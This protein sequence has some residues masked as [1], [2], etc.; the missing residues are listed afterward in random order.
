MS[1]KYLEK[2]AELEKVSLRRI[3]SEFAKGKISTP[4]SELVSKGAIKSEGVYARGMRKGNSVLAKQTNSFVQRPHSALDKALADGG[5]GYFTIPLHK[6]HNK[7]VANK[8]GFM[9]GTEVSHQASVRHE[10]FEA[11]EANHQR[12]SGIVKSI[13][14]PKILHNKEAYPVPPKLRQEVD[15]LNSNVM[16]GEMSQIT[17]RHTSP[18]GE[19]VPTIVGQHLSPRVLTR[20]SEMVR[21]NPF[22]QKGFKDVRGSTTGE[23]S[24]IQKLTGKE[25]GTERMT[26]KDHKKALL[27]KPDFKETNSFGVTTKRFDIV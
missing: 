7:I 24:L 10:L 15:R 3:I 21:K 12:K 13:D 19:S 1:N 8:S 4:L 27:A 25:Y 14:M 22:L 20:E 11:M 17:R 18:S 16:A 2:I 26:G 9:G 23:S 6:G 5:G